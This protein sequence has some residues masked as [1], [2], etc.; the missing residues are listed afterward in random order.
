[1]NNISATLKQG[2]PDKLNQDQNGSKNGEQ[3]DISEK[4][5]QQ[6]HE[7]KVS[8]KKRKQLHN[9]E[10][11]QKTRRKKKKKQPEE[12]DKLDM[13]IEKYRNK[14]SQRGNSDKSEDAPSSGNKEVRRWFESS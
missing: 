11:T 3:S 10:E 7:S 4:Q 5:Q 14:F 9:D 12:I 13:L 6:Q 2:K 8:S 1:M